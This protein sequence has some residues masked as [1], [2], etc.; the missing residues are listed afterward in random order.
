MPPNLVYKRDDNGG[1]G[2]RRGGGGGW[3]ERGGGERGRGMQDGGPPFKYHTQGPQQRNFPSGNQHNNSY[4]NRQFHN[5]QNSNGSMG[6]NGPAPHTHRSEPLNLTWQRPSQTNL[7]SNYSN[8]HANS[9]RQDHIKYHD[10]NNYDRSGRPPRYHHQHHHHH[11]H[12]SPPQPSSPAFSINIINPSATPP[13]PGAKEQIFQSSPNY[14]NISNDEPDIVMGEEYVKNTSNWKGNEWQRGVSRGPPSEGCDEYGGKEGYGGRGT[15]KWGDRGSG[16]GR[17][18]TYDSEINYDSSKNRV[19]YKDSSEEPQVIAFS[20]SKSSGF[21][22]FRATAPINANGFPSNSPFSST[23]SGFNGFSNAPG[24][25]GIGSMP[26]PTPIS[27]NATMATSGFGLSSNGQS[28]PISTDYK[29]PL[30]PFTPVANS[31]S[32][33]PTPAP[34]ISNP[35]S[36]ACLGG[37]G[38]IGGGEGQTKVTKA[39]G[40][41]RRPEDLSDNN[42]YLSALLKDARLGLKLDL[43][44]QDL[45]VFERVKRKGEFTLDNLPEAPPPRKFVLYHNI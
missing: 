22:G 8:S 23:L 33:F 14:P 11:H 40:P 5:Q 27:F 1:G 38:I 36:D 13:F 37:I 2:G 6:H 15:G 7:P 4:H 29:P 25:V 17:H 31:F 39:S 35:T 32:V 42:G 44:D 20:G 21:L 18:F 16:T 10:G 12:P 9:S 30:N 45:E 3:D 43:S 26:S 19:R 24:Q 34:T 28:N 41:V